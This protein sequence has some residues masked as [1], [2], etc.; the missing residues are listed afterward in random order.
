MKARASKTFS[1]F[2]RGFTQLVG[3]RL[4]I[5]DAERRFLAYREL[6][7]PSPQRASGFAFGNLVPVEV[8]GLEG[9]A[10]RLEAADAGEL[11]RLPRIAPE[12]AAAASFAGAV[13]D[14]ESVTDP[15]PRTAHG[16][17][18]SV[19]ADAQGRPGP[20]ADVGVFHLEGG[21]ILADEARRRG[22]GAL[23]HPADLAVELALADAEAG[24]ERGLDVA[25]EPVVAQ[26]AGRIGPRV[27]VQGVPEAERA[28]TGVD[29]EGPCPL[30]GQSGRPL[31]FLGRGGGSGR[32]CG[33][34]L[35]GDGARRNEDTENGEEGRAPDRG[36]RFSGRSDSVHG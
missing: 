23:A 31:L 4:E 26:V 32:G 9:V 7:V 17:L 36:L 6:V 35:L 8:E 1:P 5:G 28:H 13:P 33:H 12:A 34:R 24:R 30:L 16:E 2:R 3:A 14:Q 20:P 22:E 15:V 10:L 21:G 25:L 27:G 11:P 19:L 29:V 18:E